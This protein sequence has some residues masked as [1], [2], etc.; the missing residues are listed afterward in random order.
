MEQTETEAEKFI[1]KLIEKYPL[2]I[3]SEYPEEVE[4]MLLEAMQWAVE[5]V[6]PEERKFKSQINMPDGYNP[7]YL[8]DVVYCAQHNITNAFNDCRN[9]IISTSKEIFGEK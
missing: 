2:G 5:R 3:M 8:P 1:W 7:D 4:K 9:H 6:I